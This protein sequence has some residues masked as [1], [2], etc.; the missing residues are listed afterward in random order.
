[1]MSKPELSTRA[2]MCRHMPEHSHGTAR[3][4]TEDKTVSE[5]HSQTEG[6]L[7]LNKFCAV[8]CHAK[9]KILIALVSS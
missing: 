7:N 4:G 9:S 1:M 6:M 3:G 8:P 2:V 5:K